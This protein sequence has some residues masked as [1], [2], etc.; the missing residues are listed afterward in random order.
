MAYWLATL[1]MFVQR[2][3][4]QLNFSPLHFT[5]NFINRI[6]PDLPCLIY[7]RKIIASH[8]TPFSNWSLICC[9][10]LKA[11]KGEA[12][13]RPTL[14]MT[15]DFEQSLFPE[16][17]TIIIMFTIYRPCIQIAK[18]LL[19]KVTGK[20]SATGSDQINWHKPTYT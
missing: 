7:L 17:I 1:F 12:Y 2:K 15:I 9:W 19:Q 10:L 14:H 3:V 13:L 4:Q 16:I 8:F 5:T 11:F 6:K 20:Y 18:E